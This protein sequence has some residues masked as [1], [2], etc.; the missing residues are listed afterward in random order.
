[1]FS[2]NIQSFLICNGLFSIKYTT[3]CFL[4][5]SNYWIRMF[6]SEFSGLSPT[7]GLCTSCQRRAE[8]ACKRCT[9]MYC[10]A[11]CQRKDWQ[12]HRYICFP[13]PSLMPVGDI[14]LHGC[15]YGMTQLFT[16]PK[17]NKDGSTSADEL[18]NNGNSEMNIEIRSKFCDTAERHVLVKFISSNKCVVRSLIQPDGFTD[19]L[20]KIHVLGKSAPELNATPS[21]GSVALLLYKGIY[22]RVEVLLIQHDKAIRV[23]FCDYGMIGTATKTDFRV[24]LDDVLKFPRLSSVIKLQNVQ[25]CSASKIMNL[26]QKFEGLKCELRKDVVPTSG[27]IV[28]VF[29]IMCES[30]NINEEINKMMVRDVKT[31]QSLENKIVN[32]NDDLLLDFNHDEPCQKGSPIFSP[33][34][35]IYVFQTDLVNFKV[36]VLD[37]SALSYGYVGCIAETD[38]KYLVTV[39]EYLNQYVDDGK[40]YNPKLYEYCL[41]KF[42]NDWYRA[43]VVKILGNSL[44]TVVYLDFTNEGTISSQDIRR[45][46]NELNG[47][48]RTNLCLIDGLPTSLNADH[49]KFLRGEITTERKLLIGKVKEVLQQIVVVECQHIIKKMSDLE[50]I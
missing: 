48:C 34:F 14:E 32:N 17:E 47:S 41:A 30:L 26:L 10:S 33:P 38:L 50:L 5:R 29:T 44:Y 37:T 3:V 25:E 43:R 20:K 13:M 27:D 1:M 15:E 46:P 42:E 45:Y 22:S 7:W 16:K 4:L 24:A 28:E 12:R 35:D 19:I 8:W 6:A 9:D 18:L 21:V 2:D 11:E 23:L 36:V 49:I 40:F 39:Q 31:S